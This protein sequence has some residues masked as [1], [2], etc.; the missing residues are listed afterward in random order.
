ME[1]LASI[2]PRSLAPLR[3]VNGFAPSAVTPPPRTLATLVEQFEERESYENPDLIVRVSSLRLD[4]VEELLIVPTLG[5]FR[6]TDWSRHQLAL[7]VGLK[8]DRW[9]ENASPSE[10]AEELNR[11]FARATGDVRVRTRRDDNSEHAGV[12]TALV[13]PGYSPVRDSEMAKRL[14]ASLSAVDQEQSLVRVDV[15]D[16]STSYVVRVGE[17]YRVGGPGEVG[18]LWGCLL[19]RNS[20]VGFASLLVTLSLYRLMCRNGMFAPLPDAVLIRRRHRALS[21]DKL[22]HILV[23]RLRDMPG[24]LAAG[25]DILLASRARRLDDVPLAVRRV[26]EAHHLP[27]KLVPAILAAYD[28]EPHASAFGLTQALTLAAQS[29]TPEIRVELERAAGEYLAENNDNDAA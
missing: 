17:P 25:A 19:V 11:R 20:G 18:D 4:P 27:V 10:K 3:V 7:L 16:R 21:P 26:L 14:F 5:A 24:K 2:A 23:E 12:V 28:R 9:V 13:S 22:D 6:F 29:E 15:T 1:A 8:W